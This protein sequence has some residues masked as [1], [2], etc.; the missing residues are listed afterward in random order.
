MKSAGEEK[1][2]Q[3]SIALCSILAILLIFCFDAS[4]AAVVE[5]QGQ[6]SDNARASP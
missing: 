6:L 3:V 4:P 2:R 1:S 5:A